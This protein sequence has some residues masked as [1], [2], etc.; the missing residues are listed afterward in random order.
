MDVTP[1]FGQWLK[2][3]RR[4]MGLT[5]DALGEQVGCAGETIRKIE[6]G[7]VRPSQHLAQLLAARLD[8][9]AEEQAAFV[10]WARGT[11][12]PAPP[13]LQTAGGQISTST[14][15]YG[16]PDPAGFLTSGS[17]GT[18]VVVPASLRASSTFATAVTAA[19]RKPA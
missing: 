14:P 15:V 3:R 4:S 13:L 5:Q 19:V 1:G 11:A 10:K 16:I 12:G 7:G 9:S 17:T 18:A 6:A 8:L 2:A